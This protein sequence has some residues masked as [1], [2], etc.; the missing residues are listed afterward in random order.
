MTTIVKVELIKVYYQCE[1][2]RKID[3]IV[4]Y[5]DQNILSA[6]ECFSCGA[7]ARKHERNKVIEL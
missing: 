7:T 3:F 4:Y 5:K 2:C 6:V 1:Q